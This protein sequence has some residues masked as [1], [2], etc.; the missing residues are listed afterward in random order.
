L[1]QELDLYMPCKGRKEQGSV[2]RHFALDFSS[3]QPLS[4]EK[5]KEHV[6]AQL[7]KKF[8]QAGPAS[9]QPN[10]APKGQNA[11]LLKELDAR[12]AALLPLAEK[13]FKRRRRADQKHIHVP[14]K[15]II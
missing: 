4:Q 8:G 13:D 9:A 1:L 10:T 3:C 2:Y 12:V 11:A 7:V 6:E 5:C 14:L 15:A